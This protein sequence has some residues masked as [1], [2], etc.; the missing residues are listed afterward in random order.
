MSFDVLII[1]PSEVSVEDLSEVAA[2]D[3]LGD[4]SFVESAINLVFPGAVNGVWLSEEFSV[5]ALIN[6]T[7]AESAQI[8]LRFGNSWSEASEANFLSFLSSICRKI[9]AVAFAVSDNSKLAP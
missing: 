7:P 2:V 3:P 5:E 6:G 4:I 9:D 1:K 8:T